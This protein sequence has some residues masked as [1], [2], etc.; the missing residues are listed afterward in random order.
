MV[1]HE[2][3]KFRR[4]PESCRR[5]ILFALAKEDECHFSLAQPRGGFD[6]GVQYGLQ[7]KRRTANDL[8]HVRGRRLLLQRFGEIVRTLPQF[9]EQ[10]CILDR[11]HRLLRKVA[12]QFDLLVRERTNFLAIDGHRA[13]HLVIPQHGH[14]NNGACAANLD[15][16][17]SGSG[18]FDVGRTGSQVRDLSHVLGLDRRRQHASGR[19]A[20]RL[21]T[22]HRGKRWI[23]IIARDRAYHAALEQHHRSEL[24]AANVDC[25][26]QHLV[27]H[28]GKIRRRRTDDLQDLGGRGLL[29]KGFL[30]IVRLG[31]YLVEQVDIA[32]RDHRLVGEGLNEL[33]LLLA[34]R[35]SNEAEQADDAERLPIPNERYAEC[36]PDAHQL[37]CTLTLPLRIDKH[38]GNMSSAAVDNCATKD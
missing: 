2:R 1:L 22:S 13:D 32:D 28:R 3:P 18:T 35:A 33:D 36:R 10:S 14:D 8:E 4:R 20:I 34:E 16:V 38:V 23:I 5:P 31:L 7:I 12:E 15:Q 29:L 24:G 37:L 30:E 21:I 27:E 19:W 6:K 25:V 9:P 17:D 11:D 26:L